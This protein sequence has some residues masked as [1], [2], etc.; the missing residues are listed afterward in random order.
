MLPT[1]NWIP[2]VLDDERFPVVDIPLPEPIVGR[3]LDF[4]KNEP[5]TELRPIAMSTITS[6]ELN[7]ATGF[8]GRDNEFRATLEA[9]LILGSVYGSALIDRMNVPAVRGISSGSRGELPTG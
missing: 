1:N 6:G 7:E 9:K 4:A 8:V 3:Y 2:T 5:T